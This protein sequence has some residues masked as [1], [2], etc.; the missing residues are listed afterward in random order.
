MGHGFTATGDQPMITLTDAPS[1]YN[2]LWIKQ[3]H[4]NP[5]QYPLAT[6]WDWGNLALNTLYAHGVVNILGSN[7]ALNI[8]DSGGYVSHVSLSHDGSNSRLTSN[9]GL[10][11]T[12][13]MITGSEAFWFYG[14]DVVIRGGYHLLP[15]IDGGGQV[16][17]DGR[18]WGQVWTADVRANNFDCFGG[19]SGSEAGH[20]G[21][22]S[23]RYYELW[24][25]V[26]HGYTNG[27][28]DEY[29]DLAIVKQ[30]GE[31]QPKIPEN[32]NPSKQKPK[33][34][35][36]FSMLRSQE[37]DEYFNIIELLNF[38][39]SV[40][41]AL[42]KKQDEC[43]QILLEVIDE[44][45]RMSKEITDLRKQLQELAAKSGVSA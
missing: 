27:G 44:K 9:S 25:R 26:F 6:Q 38:S 36:P 35:D 18:L 19:G 12:A 41:K 28:Y 42:A 33:D 3:G 8:C 13:S 21:S 31:K 29:D 4:S 1:G 7:A 30:W 39:L 45:E 20:L 5:D 34:N 10:I 14:G 24:A 37:G 40:G 16:G 23:H 11:V 43:D 17:R 22:S 32:Y 15:E 2:T